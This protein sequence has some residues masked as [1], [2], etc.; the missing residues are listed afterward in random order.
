[1]RELVIVAA[2]LFMLGGA[3]F[4]VVWAVSFFR[5]SR[6]PGSCYRCGQPTG[7]PRRRA[8]GLCIS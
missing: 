2:Q 8:C 7:H 5:A 4:S 3:I 1:V 6:K